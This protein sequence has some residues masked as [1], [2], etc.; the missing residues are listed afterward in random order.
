MNPDAMHI[1]QLIFYYITKRFKLSIITANLLTAQIIN[2]FNLCIFLVGLKFIY[3]TQI[4]ALLILFSIAIYTGAY[5]KL[6]VF[7]YKKGV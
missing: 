6:F 7:K 2:F 3:N 4:Q 1:H 5:F